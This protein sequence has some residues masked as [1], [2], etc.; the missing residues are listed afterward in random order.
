MAVVTVP[1]TPRVTEFYN[2]NHSKSD[3]KFTSGGSAKPN[4][5]GVGGTHLPESRR[6]GF[7]ANRAQRKSLATKKAAARDAEALNN[8]YDSKG[9]RTEIKP[10]GGPMR[11]AGE[12]TKAKEEAYQGRLADLRAK[13]GY[14]GDV[15]NVHANIIKLEGIRSKTPAQRNQLRAAR[16]FA[17]SWRMIL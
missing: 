15:M 10:D 16:A 14:K 9:R 13:T 1:A 4:S 17:K 3:G 11:L 12:K 7:E 8:N 2:K 6:R 5:D